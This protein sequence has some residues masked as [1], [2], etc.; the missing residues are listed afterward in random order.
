MAAKL[1]PH[2]TL[3]N[4]I[5]NNFIQIFLSTAWR[6]SE[7]AGKAEPLRVAASQSTMKWEQFAGAFFSA[8]G[9]LCQS[10]GTPGPGL[11]EVGKG[12]GGS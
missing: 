9:L 12:P 4:N 2:L 1:L 8:A 6:K 3:I 7:K 11:A 5:N 10:V